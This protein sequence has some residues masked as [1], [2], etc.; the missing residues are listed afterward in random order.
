MSNNINNI[1][2]S[3]SNTV[4]AATSTIDVSTELLNEASKLAVGTVRGLLPVTK[5]T[6]RALGIFGTAL[7][8][9]DIKEDADV[10]AKYD[11]ITVQ[12]ILADA[13]TA[14]VKAARFTAELFSEEAE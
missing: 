7:F 1:K 12:S 11:S 10:V 14:A 4:D 8:N 6:F 2:S 5:G 13:D 9:L 3:V